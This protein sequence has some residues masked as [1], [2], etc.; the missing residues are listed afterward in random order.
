MS[1]TQYLQKRGQTWLVVVEVPK[2]LQRVLGKRRLMKSLQTQSLDEANR[3]KHAVV[4]EMKLRLDLLARTPDQVEAKALARAMVYRGEYL[5]ASTQKFNIPDTDEFVSARGMVVDDIRSD[6]ERLLGT[7]GDGVADRFIKLATAQVTPLAGLP[8]QWLAETESAVTGQTLKQHAFAVRHFIEWAG[9]ESISIEDI[10]RLKAG[11]YLGEAL[12]S[13]ERAPKT[14]KRHMSSLSGFWTWL[15][16]RGH[17][18]E[19]PFEGHKYGGSKK[20]SSTRRPFNDEELTKLLSGKYTGHYNETLH[21]LIR[22]A[23]V[24]GARLNELCS[25]KLTDVERLNDGWSMNILKGKTEAATRSVPLHRSVNAII[26]KRTA[27]QTPYLFQELTTG[28][29]DEKHM[30]YASK[31]FKR[32][33]TKVGLPERFKDFHSL[34]NTFIEAMEGAEVTEATVKLLVGHKRASMT[35]GLYSKGARVDLRAAIDRLAYTPGVMALIG[36]RPASSLLTAV[37]ILQGE[38]RLVTK[39]KGKR[40]TRPSS[41]KSHS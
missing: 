23:L 28:G 10:T 5:L 36:E 34:R 11:A 41:A 4:A 9:G 38:R 30:W 6:W 1:N 8:E 35:Y 40:K 39:T 2:A 24:S 13:G 31:A 33:R 19:N 16:S 15:K 7:A 14:V 29:P 17:A 22:L 27:A 37:E 25:L 12:R 26:E 18:K 20:G 32:Y 3:K 21:D